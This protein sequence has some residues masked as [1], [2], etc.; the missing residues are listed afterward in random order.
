MKDVDNEETTSAEEVADFSKTDRWSLEK[1]MWVRHHVFP[2]RRTF[3]PRGTRDGPDP[4]QLED[5]RVTTFIFEN[6]DTRTSQDNWTSAENS[7][8]TLDRHFDLL[9]ATQIP[10]STSRR[11]NRR[12]T[13]RQGTSFSDRA[14]QGGK[15]T[16]QLDTSSLQILVQDLRPRKGKKELRA[17]AL[18]QSGPDSGGLR[19]PHE[20]R[21]TSADNMPYF[22]GCDYRTLRGGSCDQEGPGRLHSE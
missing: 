14:K 10:T 9:R 5:K 1:G 17:T 20:W 13:S 21:W 8:S 2:R 7:R 18:H 22:N 3:G 19:F 4:H 15:G 12:C 16:S 11:S 6:G